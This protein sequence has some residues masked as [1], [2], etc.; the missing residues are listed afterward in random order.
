MKDKEVNIY[1]LNM[2]I[3][4]VKRFIEDKYLRD[5]FYKRSYRE[6]CNRYYDFIS[7]C[8]TNEEILD[9]LESLY[10][11]LKIKRLNKFHYSK[12]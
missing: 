12:I 10:S 5:P 11:Y 8:D 1:E 4:T 9:S 3:G 6:I 2:N 7:Y